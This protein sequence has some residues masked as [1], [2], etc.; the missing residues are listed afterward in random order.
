MTTMRKQ[1]KFNNTFHERRQLFRLGA[2]ILLKANVKQTFFHGYLS[3]K[4]DIF[5][6]KFTVFQE[7]QG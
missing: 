4:Y 3:W 1:L 7:K 6:M 2:N 5:L